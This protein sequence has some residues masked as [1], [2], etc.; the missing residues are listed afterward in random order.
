MYKTITKYL[1]YPIT[2]VQ[3]QKEWG[4]ENMDNIMAGELF[5]MDDIKSHIQKTR[6]NTGKNRKEKTNT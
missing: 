6:K 2:G 3:E 5:R 4:R 1:P